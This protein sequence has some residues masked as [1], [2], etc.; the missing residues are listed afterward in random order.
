MRLRSRNK[1]RRKESNENIKSKMPSANEKR[2][3][4]LLRRKGIYTSLS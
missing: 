3:I 1:L 4:A 2:A